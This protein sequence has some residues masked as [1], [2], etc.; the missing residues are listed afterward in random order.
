MSS[1][2]SLRA[3]NTKGFAFVKCRLIKWDYAFFKAA[4]L[5][6]LR[7]QSEGQRDRF[8]TFQGFYFAL[9][10]TAINKEGFFVHDCWCCV[11][12]HKIFSHENIRPLICLFFILSRLLFESNARQL[13]GVQTMMNGNSLIIFTKN[14]FT[15]LNKSLITL[16]KQMV[17]LSLAVNSI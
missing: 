7:H 6:S 17:I 11:I 9:H 5:V 14:C 15:I 1:N 13:S 16:V 8:F 2:W 3:H 12:E 4:F 10:Q